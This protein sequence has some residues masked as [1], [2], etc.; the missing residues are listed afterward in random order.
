MSDYVR[1]LP[2]V[3]YV[4]TVLW[5][6]ICLRVYTMISRDNPVQRRVIAIGGAICAAMIFQVSGALVRVLLAAPPPAEEA[7]RFHVEPTPGKSK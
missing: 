7:P 5:A 1:F 4:L 3:P 6:L 2:A